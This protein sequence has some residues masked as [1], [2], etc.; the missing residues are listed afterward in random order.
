MIHSEPIFR[1][2]FSIISGFFTAKVPNIM[3]SAPIS[4]SS[5]A[6]SKV[7]IPPPICTLTIS[8]AL[9]II[10]FRSSLF[11]SEPHA[12]S[13]STKCNLCAP[14]LTQKSNASRGFS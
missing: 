1:A 10:F 9:I 14:C 3:R 8:E 2:S 11:L 4:M 7:L 12:P 6:A 13:K 5:T